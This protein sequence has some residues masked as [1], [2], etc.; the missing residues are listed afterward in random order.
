ME[1][2]EAPQCNKPEPPELA[3]QGLGAQGIKRTLA[4]PL[5]HMR[6]LYVR[7]AWTA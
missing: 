1:L 2:F 7:D 6:C 5:E 3:D 4:R